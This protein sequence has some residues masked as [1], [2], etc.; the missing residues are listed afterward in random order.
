M[1]SS[2]PNQDIN[3]NKLTDNDE[4]AIELENSSENFKISDSHNK[5]SESLSN[6]SDENK[7]PAKEKADKKEGEIWATIEVNAYWGKD[8]D[9]KSSY[10][11]NYPGQKDNE[12]RTT[13][14][15]WY[16]FIPLTLF[17]QY[18]VLSNIYYIFVLIVS[19]LPMSPLSYLFQLVPMLVVLIISMI[20]SGV[21]DLMK[22]FEDKKRNE[23]P[24]LRYDKELG[25][26]SQ[27]KACELHV[28]DI[29]K[30]TE[31]MMV[32]SDCLFIGSTQE[33]SLCYFS[34]TSLNG[35]TAVKTMQPHPL[36]DKPEYKGNIDEIV[37]KVTS[38]NEKFYVDLPEPDR[39]LTRFDAR[40]KTSNQFWPININNVLLRGT[41]THYTEDVIGIVLRTGHDTKVM[42]NIKLPPAKLTK[43]DK[44]LNRILIIVFVLKVILC[45]LSTFLGVE[46]DKGKKFPLIK[47]LSKSYG[48]AWLEYFT[49]YFVLYSYLF[50]ISLT[51]TIEII[52]LFHKAI[53]SYDPYLYDP[54]FGHGTAHNSNVIGQLGLVTHILSDKT[55]TLTE[56]QM[57][58]LNFTTEKGG[59]F[60]SVD[61]LNSIESDKSLLQ[62]N[63]DFL[64]ALA[65]CNNVIV[66]IK[67]DGTIE[68][69]ADSPDESAFVSFAANCGVR[70]IARNLTSFKID[71]CGQCY[72]YKIL[73]KIPFNS[74]RKRM[75]IVVSR[76]KPSSQQ[77]QL[78]NMLDNINDELL[79][80]PE[81]TNTN[82]ND[83]DDDDD[84]YE[85]AIIYTKGADNI[86]CERIQNYGHKEQEKV[87]EFAALGLRTLVFASREVKN[88]EL[89]EWLNK[90]REAEASLNDR[91]EMIFECAASIEKNLSYIGISGVEDKLQ[92]EVPQT[93]RWIRAAGI[94]LWVLT[95]DK[96][97]TAVAIGKTSGIIIPNSETLIISTQHEDEIER[98]IDLYLNDFPKTNRTSCSCSNYSDYASDYDDVSLYPVLVM[99]ST[100]LEL[101]INKCLD[102]FMSLADRCHSVILC[103]VSPFM[104][105]KVTTIV[106]E[107]ISKAQTLAVG[108]GAND[109]GMIQVA[110]VG[111]GI[112][113][114]EGSQA[115]MSSDV[116]IL[117]F[118]HL[119]RTLMVHGHWSYRRMSH[120]AI[121]MIYKNIVFISAQLWFS[122]FNL[123]SPT[124]YYS[125]FV[126]SCFNLVFTALPPFIFGFWEQDLDQDI[127]ESS[128][129]LY[130][131]EYDPM[132][133]LNLF[134]YIILG[135]FQS[136]VAYFIPFIVTPDFSLVESGILTY[137]IAV[138]IVV[139]Q[140]MMWQSFQNGWTFGLY[141]VN[142]V[143]API[144]IVIYCK[145]IS[146]NLADV[147]N[148]AM[149]TTVFWMSFIVGVVLGILPSFIYEYTMKRYR[150][151]KVR[152][153]QERTVRHKRKVAPSKFWFNPDSNNEGNVKLQPQ[154]SN[155]LTSQANEVSTASFNNS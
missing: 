56:N 137:M 147:V 8:K 91:D 85:T 39:D 80:T 136:L 72:E 118:K 2:S 127:L 45:I 79:S 7:A 94:K 22:H 35:E 129:E 90:Y 77:N 64:L 75:S 1:S 43:F 99:T 9:K 3:Q 125:G 71:V 76:K 115:A 50:P 73:A 120:V 86:M 31:D 114:R 63:L 103:R 33:N 87:N 151:S 81:Q 95:G 84:E 123:W 124:S 54:D 60:Y 4:G 29:L 66:Y 46:Y 89:E 65:I 150:P 11:K 18:R 148:H 62:A 23:F 10:V 152:I 48:M 20:K 133:T 53:F 13:R 88:V 130:P 139:C 55:G 138:Y 153:H 69:N 105:A 38:E 98:K 93:I 61:F 36:F 116:A 12:V 119:R 92:S 149:D 142:I 128:P 96:L 16:T 111:V 32:P 145:F 21:E 14:Y 6:S 135:L 24:V 100:S 109:V 25:N 59:S 102:K 74:D 126:M 143:L 132:S 101:A 112:Y 97:E 40:L 106:K 117:R 49:Q 67:N 70:L 15:R 140:V 144:I 44:N 19:F 34:E 26:F 5:S 58:L 82:D 113:G 51:V 41:A 134:Y 155:S 42:K 121:I 107:N 68:Y 83:D 122:F 154:S 27:T 78:S 110:D 108:D 52:R 104:K 28:G 47:D 57:E 141:T 131:V 17:E 30:I 146:G 37:R